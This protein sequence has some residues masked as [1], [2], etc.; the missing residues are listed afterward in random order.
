MRSWSGRCGRPSIP[1]AASHR[2]LGH[3]DRLAATST[4]MR[5]SGRGRHRL[6]AYGWLDGPFQRQRPVPT[7]WPSS[8][9]LACAG[10]DQHHPARQIPLIG[11]RAFSWTAATSGRWTLPHQRPARRRDGRRRAA[12][13]S[14]LRGRRPTGR[15]HRRQARSRAGAPQGNPLRPDRPDARDVCHGLDGARC[16][17]RR[18][19][20]PG[21]LSDDAERLANRCESSEDVK[22]ALEAYSDLLVAEGVH[23]VVSGHADIAGEA[24]D[25][26]AG[27]SRPPAV[28]FVRTP[29]SGYRLATSVLAVLAVSPAG[30]GRTP[31]R[32]RRRLARGIPGGALLAVALARWEWR[33]SPR[34][35]TDAGRTLAISG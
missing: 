1:P 29:P 20:Y 13:L 21:V 31:D 3:R 28:E 8:C 15:G 11:R 18:R 9:A 33:R 7:G 19:D 22:A 5:R 10:D 14:H 32:T 35:E 17:A 6:G 4:S 34:P 12:G 16:A 26:A 24:M 2:P 23:Q 30:R 25:A 27:F